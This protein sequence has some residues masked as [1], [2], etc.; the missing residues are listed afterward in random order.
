MT[1]AASADELKAPLLEVQVESD[2]K[3]SEQPHAAH[4]FGLWVSAAFTGAWRHILRSVDQLTYLVL[5]PPSELC[6]GHR[7]PR[8]VSRNA[9]QAGAPSAPTRRH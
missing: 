4:G 5:S 2:V 8:C 9:S 7:L 3:E 1:A 6:D